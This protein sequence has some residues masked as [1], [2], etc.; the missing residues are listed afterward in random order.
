MV[1]YVN[2]LGDDNCQGN[3]ESPSGKWNETLDMSR[4]LGL[5]QYIIECLA[6]TLRLSVV[7]TLR[8]YILN[9]LAYLRAEGDSDPIRWYRIMNPGRIHLYL[10]A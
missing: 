10:C 5:L 1:V 9:F 3:P 7:A 2:C 6:T 4:Y 8:S